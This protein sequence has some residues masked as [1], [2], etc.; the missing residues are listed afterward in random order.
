[1]DAPSADKFLKFNLLD[2]GAVEVATPN[3]RQSEGSGAALRRPVK[4]VSFR[5]P[6]RPNAAR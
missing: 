2:T 6:T 5:A 1:M 4:H 3:R